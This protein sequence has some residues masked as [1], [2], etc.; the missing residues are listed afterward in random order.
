MIPTCYKIIGENDC[1]E[2]S[3]VVASVVLLVVYPSG[4]SC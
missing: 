4:K 3:I 1:L 2:L